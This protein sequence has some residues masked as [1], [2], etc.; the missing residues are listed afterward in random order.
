MFEREQAMC[1]E[2]LMGGMSD[3][4]HERVLRSAAARLGSHSTQCE[5]ERDVVAMLSVGRRNEYVPPHSP[6]IE[7]SQLERAIALSG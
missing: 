4:D 5:K 1:H 2:G 3:V 7:R 6:R